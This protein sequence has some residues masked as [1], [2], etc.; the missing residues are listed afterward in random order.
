MKQIEFDLKK[1][2][3]GADIVRVLHG[4]VSG[5]SAMEVKPFF[6]DSELQFTESDPLEREVVE[7][8]DDYALVVRRKKEH[9]TIN[10]DEGKPHKSKE[11]T[12]RMSK[13]MSGVNDEGKY[14]LHG[15]DMI[16][17]TI[18]D[19]IEAINDWMNRVDQGYVT[20]IQGDIL[21]QYLLS[22][23]VPKSYEPKNKYG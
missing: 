15:I 12:F 3:S 17:A 19:N 13:Y 2:M 21:C 7:S 1:G 20:R 9:A 10:T 11:I 16:P 8:N 14:F 5:E 6:E 18:P 4:R 22:S 23:Q